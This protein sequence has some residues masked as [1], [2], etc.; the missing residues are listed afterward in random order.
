MLFTSQ[1][2]SVLGETVPS[3]AVSKTSGTVF[4]NTDQPWLVNNIY[5]DYFFSFLLFSPREKK[6]EGN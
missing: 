5:M 1:G 6:R 4:P 3:L 2:R